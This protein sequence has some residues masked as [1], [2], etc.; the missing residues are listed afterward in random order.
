MKKNLQLGLII[1][2]GYATSAACGCLQ[3]QAAATFN[4]LP[5]FLFPVVAGIVLGLTMGI[6]RDAAK[7]RSM[8]RVIAGFLL[9]VVS[10]VLQLQ[11]GNILRSQYQS[12]T[13]FSLAMLGTVL[14]RDGVA[15]C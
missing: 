7:A 1:V 5:L 2:F 3:K 6:G 11:F 8:P 15:T 13:T 9:L 4:V 10:A 14:L 12:V